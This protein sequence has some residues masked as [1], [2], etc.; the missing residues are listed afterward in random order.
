MTSLRLIPLILILAA[1]APTAAT[2]AM[3]NPQSDAAMRKGIRDYATRG[4]EG[5]ALKVKATNI[6]C[7]QA[8]KVGS[9]G[10]CRGS[11]TLT[12][13]GRT[14][15]YRLTTMARTVRI[16][17]GAMMYHLRATSTRSA[18]GMPTTI[19]FTGILQ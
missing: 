4:V 8:A 18:P 16:A 12:Y 17:Q 15:R 13:Q 3:K 10:R 6:D 2:A 14:V 5:K 9:T 7:T 11:F 1:I 19:S